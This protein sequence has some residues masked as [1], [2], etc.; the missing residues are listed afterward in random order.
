MIDI[1]K[2][3]NKLGNIT[4]V[5]DDR[6][7]KTSAETNILLRFDEK[8]LFLL[9]LGF[10]LSSYYFLFKLYIGER[11]LEK[12]SKHKIRLNYDCVNRTTLKGLRWSILFIFSLDRTP[13][14]KNFVNQR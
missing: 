10:S 8:S 2:K 14:Y 4:V 3:S 1:N 13:E 12:I 11:N 5:T 9:L 7:M 6:K